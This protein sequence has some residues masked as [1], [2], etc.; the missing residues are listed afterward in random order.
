MTMNIKKLVK[1]RPLPP[2]AMELLIKTRT[3]LRRLNEKRLVLRKEASEA[4][5]I[6]GWLESPWDYGDI[7]EEKPWNEMVRKKSAMPRRFVI[8]QV[9]SFRC[10]G[11]LL[12][13]DGTLGVDIHELFREFRDNPVGRYTGA[14]LPELPPGARAA[15]EAKGTL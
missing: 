2:K 6:I 5:E 15:M 9:G 4:S 14:D 10:F 1:E 12:K 13:K 3:N 11:R 8:I 7:V